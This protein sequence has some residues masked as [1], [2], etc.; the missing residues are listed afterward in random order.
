MKL[1]YQRI[2]YMPPSSLERQGSRLIDYLWEAHRAA[3][4]GAYADW[5]PPVDVYHTAQS[6]EVTLEVAGMDEED[7]EVTLFD[8]VVVV[9]GE[10][11]PKAEPSADLRYQEAGIR[12]GRFRAEILLP[13]PVLGERVEA[14]YVDG[15]LRITMPKQEMMRIQAVSQAGTDANE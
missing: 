4:A 13:S 3:L 7:F 12:Y 1:R 5:R 15:M 9:E 8:D 14:R 2:N 10:R 11:K 6:V